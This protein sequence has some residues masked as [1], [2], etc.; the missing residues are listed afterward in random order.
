MVEAEQAVYGYR[1]VE[2]PDQRIQEDPHE[3]A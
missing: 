1:D 2:Y 3:T